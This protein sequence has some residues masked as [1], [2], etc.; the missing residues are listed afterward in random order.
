MKVWTKLADAGGQPFFRRY[1]KV[2]E[3]LAFEI[4]DPELVTTARRMAIVYTALH[5]FE[6]SVRKLVST[7]RFR[8]SF[9]HHRDELGRFRARFSGY[10][11]EQILAQRS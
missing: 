3:A 11:I 9:V 6:N 1:R 5:A 2:R 10:G 4:L 7:L 8:R